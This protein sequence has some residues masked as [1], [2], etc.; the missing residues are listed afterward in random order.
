MPN[1]HIQKCH[2]RPEQLEPPTQFY[3]RELEGSLSRPNH[4]GWSA[5]P[6][7]PFHHSENH[8]RK[9]S[10]PFAVRLDSGGFYCLKCGAGGKDIVAFIMV[11]DHL[12]FKAAAQR[13]GVWDAAPSPETVRKIMAADGEREDER[14]LKQEQR[15]REH[16]AL[17]AVREQIHLSIQF[18]RDAR[19]RLDELHAG[20]D[21]ITAPGEAEDCWAIL[22]L[23]LDRERMLACEYFALA[24]LGVRCGN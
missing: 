5:A 14:R 23:A 8:G 16:D 15:E 17:M 11:R 19:R 1:P 24:G 13:L 22:S 4:S 2:F 6:V 7:C 3:G 12:D 10:R 20:A 18:Q 9:K 21:S